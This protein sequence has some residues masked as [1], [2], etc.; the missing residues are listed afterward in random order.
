LV[1]A[2]IWCFSYLSRMSLNNHGEDVSRVWHTNEI[3]RKPICD[4]CTNNPKNNTAHNRVKPYRMDRHGSHHTTVPEELS[5][6]TFAEKW[7]VAGASSHVSL[8][9]L[10]NSTLGSRGYCVEVE[11]EISKLFVILSTKRSK[12]PQYFECQMVWSFVLVSGTQYY[13]PRI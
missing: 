1:E 13:V 7:P 8:I 3:Q 4:S 5:D 2:V 9:H 6:L 11:Q 12:R 10:T